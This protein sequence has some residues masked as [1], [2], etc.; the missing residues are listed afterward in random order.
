MRCP[1]Y[2]SFS[3]S[4]IDASFFACDSSAPVRVEHK[5]S[6]AA[7]LAGTLAAPSVQGHGLPQLQELWRYQH[8][9]SKPLVADSQKAS[10]PSLGDCVDLI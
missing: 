6:T 1:K 3:F 9:F 7:W 4:I 5:A 2:W 10:L 8:L